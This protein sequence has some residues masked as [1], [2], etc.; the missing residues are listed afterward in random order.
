MTISKKKNLKRSKKNTDKDKSKKESKWVEF[1]SLI[2]GVI[3]YK[4][5]GLMGLVGVAIGYVVYKYL[6]NKK[7]SKVSSI[8]SGTIAG[9]VGYLI[10]ATIYFSNIN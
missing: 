8:I 6:I 3:L 10:V 7:F 1:A 9:V 4:L 5:V 2:G